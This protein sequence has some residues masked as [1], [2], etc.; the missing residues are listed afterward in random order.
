M[1]R[2]F[3]HRKVQNQ[4]NDSGVIES[5]GKLSVINKIPRTADFL[6]VPFVFNF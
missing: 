6:V 2:T 4:K 3:A 1:N 5:F